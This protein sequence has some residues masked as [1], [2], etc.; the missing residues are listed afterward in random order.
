[1]DSL[2]VKIPEIKFSSDANEIPWENAVVWTI[3]PRLGPRVYEWLEKE[4]IRSVSWT[5]GIVSI[6][7]EKDSVLSDKCLCIV[8]PAVF[9]WIGKNVNVG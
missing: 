6:L 1:M 3:M 9:T 5:N 7:P 4:H 2:A 8:L